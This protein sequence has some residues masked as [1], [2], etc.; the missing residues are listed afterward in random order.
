MCLFFV[1]DQQNA[2]NMEE[3]KRQHDEEMEAHIKD[4]IEHLEQNL[5]AAQVSIN[6]L[7]HLI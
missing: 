5:K 6:S 4:N 7:F 2:R 3:L 1:F